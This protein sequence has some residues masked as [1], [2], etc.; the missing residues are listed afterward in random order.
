[1]TA[2]PTTKI[3]KWTEEHDSILKERFET[4]YLHDI[5]RAMG[6]SRSTVQEHARQL[7]LSKR[8]QR[9]RNSDIREFVEMEHE[10]MTYKEM[11]KRA[12]VH[13]VTVWKIANELGLKRSRDKWNDHI[14]KS[15]IERIKSEKRRIMFGLE[16]RTKLKVVC[17][18]SKHY[19]RQKLRQFGYVADK[20]SNT[21]YYTDDTVRKPIRERNGERLGFI[22]KPLPSYLCTEETGEDQHLRPCEAVD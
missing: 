14:R 16:Q 12:G 17:N 13:R 15:R 9:K 2:N 18:K 5:A 22:F 4:E 7:G 19:L 21:V 10:N 20:G 3:Q 11:A 6:F 1:M 8:E